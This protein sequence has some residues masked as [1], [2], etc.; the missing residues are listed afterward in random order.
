MA[1]SISRWRRGGSA[2]PRGWGPSTADAAEGSTGAAPGSSGAAAG[3]AIGPSAGI[4]GEPPPIAALV[5]G[6][7]TS[8]STWRV[9][10]DAVDVGT[11][12]TRTTA[13]RRA[14]IN[15]EILERSTVVSE[16]VGR[17]TMGAVCPNPGQSS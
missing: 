16:A 15:A 8:A 14:P 6:A 1:V 4:T 12:S 7:G 5:D 17:E 11:P 2:R 13:S 9:A 3:S 10:A